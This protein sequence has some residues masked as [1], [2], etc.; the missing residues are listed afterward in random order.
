MRRRHQYVVAK[1]DRTD[2]ALLH[3]LG[4]IAAFGNR[5]L[6]VIYNDTTTLKGIITAYV[7]R[8]Q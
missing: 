8:T 4:R 1:P 7:D 3:A 2:A 5:V 6:R